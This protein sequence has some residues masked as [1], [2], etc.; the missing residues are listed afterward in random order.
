MPK[1]SHLCKPWPTLTV[2][3]GV[4]SLDWIHCTW[5]VVLE[6][7]DWPSW[8]PDFRIGKDGHRYRWASQPGD[9]SQCPAEVEFDT[10]NLAL[11]CQGYRIDIVT[12]ATQSPSDMALASSARDVDE[13]YESAL[14]YLNW[15]DHPGQPD[16]DSGPT[17][18]RKKIHHLS[19]LK[20]LPPAE[21]LLSKS[22][23]YGGGDG[24]RH[25]VRA[26]LDRIGWTSSGINLLDIPWELNDEVDVGGL[27]IQDGARSSI[28]LQVFRELN[29]YFVI[30]NQ[31]F[32]ELFPTLDE[33]YDMNEFWIFMADMRPGDKVLAE[34]RLVFTQMGYVGA[35]ICD[36]LPGDEVYVLKGCKMPVILRRMENRYRLVGVGYVHGIMDGEAM[37]ELEREKTSA[38]A[39]FIY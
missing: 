4:Y 30:F 39:I 1:T 5:S 22:H 8:V 2:I 38:E 35:F 6:E 21:F 10:V 14:A 25:A 23:K 37:K 26:S 28:S 9:A 19:Q 33:N 36:V 16:R 27:S 11:K 29:E 15:K 24:L 18:I 3:K 34:G 17:M 20:N 32:K 31:N 7:D 13:V 12:A